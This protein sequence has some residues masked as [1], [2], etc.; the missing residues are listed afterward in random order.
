[1]LGVTGA[2]VRCKTRL[3]RPQQRRTCACIGDCVLTAHNLGLAPPETSRRAAPR[4]VADARPAPGVAPTTPE[5]TPPTWTD[6]RA[7]GS[8]GR[9]RCHEGPAAEGRS[10]KVFRVT[11]A[12]VRTPKHNDAELTPP[13]WLRAD[14]FTQQRAWRRARSSA[15]LVF[16]MALAGNAVDNMRTKNELV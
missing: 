9:K 1:M 11:T 3:P 12:H 13:R 16:M 14:K 7:R 2:A 6:P 10:N 5:W 15:Q 8:A 4:C